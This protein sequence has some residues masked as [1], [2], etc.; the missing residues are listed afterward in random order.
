MM[1]CICWKKMNN[2]IMPNKYSLQQMTE[3]GKGEN[4]GQDGLMRSKRI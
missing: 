3:E 1:V 4:Y 2:K